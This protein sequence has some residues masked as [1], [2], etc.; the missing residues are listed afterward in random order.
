M[1]AHQ[2]LVAKAMLL[3]NSPRNER[4]CKYNEANAAFVGKIRL[5]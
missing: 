2:L 4:G 1:A 3:V 5:P